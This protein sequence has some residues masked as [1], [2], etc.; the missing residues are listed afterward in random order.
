MIYSVIHIYMC[1]SYNAIHRYND[2][3]DD[4]KFY[5]HTAIQLN[6]MTYTDIQ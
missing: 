2:I 1:T 5:A 6:T 4:I 3:Q